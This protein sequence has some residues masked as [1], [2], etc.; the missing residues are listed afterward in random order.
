MIHFWQGLGDH[1]NDHSKDVDAGRIVGLESKAEGTFLY[2]VILMK[3]YAFGSAPVTE[4]PRAVCRYRLHVQSI[5]RRPQAH[6]HFSAR[7]SSTERRTSHVT[8]H[9]VRTL[10]GL[11]KDVS[12]L[13]SK[14]GLR[15]SFQLMHPVSS[16]TTNRSGIPMPGW[17]RLHCGFPIDWS[18]SRIITKS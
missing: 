3:I 14:I 1:C 7:C 6:L 11:T 8:G 10:G 16:G 2:M 18:E 9:F 5:H 13:R 12:D 17:K 4:T 15:P